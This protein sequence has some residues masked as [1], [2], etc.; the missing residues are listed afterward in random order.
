MSWLEVGVALAIAV[1][2]LGVVVP[3]L[4]GS[5][6]VGAAIGVWAIATGGLTAW[7]VFAI[8]VAVLV[9]GTVVKYLVP[10]RS[11]QAA[12]IPMRSLVVGAVLAVAGLFV[13]PVVGA[14]LGFVLGV[15]LAELQRLGSTLAWPSTRAALN[16]V[17]L[18]I[19][20]ET[21]AC[22]LAAATWAFGVVAT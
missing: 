14:P 16:A 21:T 6:L 20:I 1:G 10:G 15:Y 9:T 7:M 17:G 3:V 11:L 18:S 8:A 12:G 13:V 5:L 2:V 4:P 19:L 22:A